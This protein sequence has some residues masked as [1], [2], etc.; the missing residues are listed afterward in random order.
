MLPAADSEEAAPSAPGPAN[1]TRP[2]PAPRAPPRACSK[3]VGERG[4]VDACGMCGC[5]A[6]LQVSQRKRRV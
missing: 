1:P 3:A 6:L 4:P 2:P 5:L